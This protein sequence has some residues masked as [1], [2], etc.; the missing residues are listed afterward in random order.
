MH[1]IVDTLCFACLV[2]NWSTRPTHSRLWS[3]F[4][5]NHVVRPHFSKTGK[6]NFKWKQR[7]LLARLWVWPSGSLMTTVSFIMLLLELGRRRKL[8]GVDPPGHGRKSGHYF[9]PVMVSIRPKN[10]I[11]ATKDTMII[12]DHP[13]AEDWWVILN[14]LD[15]FDVVIP[16]RAEG[17]LD[18]PGRFGR[19]F[20]RWQGS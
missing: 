12:L 1:F 20:P 13:L 2:Y 7:S 17:P 9:H 16:F 19:G 14:S 5:H 8:T 10:K 11:R 15:L 4:S 3:L 6:A 18:P